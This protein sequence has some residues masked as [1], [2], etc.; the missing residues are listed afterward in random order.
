[1]LTA[2]TD[3]TAIPIATTGCFSNSVLPSVSD[4][5]YIALQRISFGILGRPLGYI[6][7]VR[8]ECKKTFHFRTPYFSLFFCKNFREVA[9]QTWS[10]GACRRPSQWLLS[11]WSYVPH[12]RLQVYL[13]AASF[14][15]ETERKS[16][17]CQ[18]TVLVTLP[19][20]FGPG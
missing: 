3:L 9:E 2:V 7:C 5:Q 14:W 11:V 17:T 6:C 4:F 19:C 12:F 15:E 10:I 20:V 16:E 1:M 8:I 13:F 18:R